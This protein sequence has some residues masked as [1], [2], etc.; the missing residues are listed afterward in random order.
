M[1]AKPSGFVGRHWNLWGA[2][3]LPNCSEG[4]SPGFAH[5]LSGQEERDGDRHR[6]LA[7]PLGM[8]RNATLKRGR[9]G[10]RT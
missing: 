9:A 5:L 10:T 1:L 4:S 6:A 7:T 2:G 3:A 8:V